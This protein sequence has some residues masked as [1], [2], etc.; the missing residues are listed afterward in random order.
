[1]GHLPSAAAG[2]PVAAADGV[3]SYEEDVA[4][5]KR[6][7]CLHF[8]LIRVTWLCPG[9]PLPKPGATPL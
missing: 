2:K 3:A 7:F 4:F 9:A 5:S 1:M 6:S 8:I